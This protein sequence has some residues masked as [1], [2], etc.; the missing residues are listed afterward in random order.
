MMKSGKP[1]FI[2]ESVEK[3]VKFYTEKLGFDLVDAATNPE[4]PNKV[5]FAEI[6]KGK[7]HIIF[8]IPYVGELAELS[9][10]KGCTG[11]G[12][13]VYVEMKKGI[14]KFFERCEK[15]GVTV[16]HQ[17]K[18]Q[19]WGVVEFMI[20][21]PFGLRLTFAQPLE[22]GIPTDMVRTFCGLEVKESEL[23][24]GLGK[25]EPVVEKMIKWLKGFG[26]LRRVAKK[27]VRVWYKRYIAIT[28]K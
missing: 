19:S 28:K 22:E 3:V 4:A 14:E 17:P 7:C 20:K 6:R 21:D 24:S 8:R 15:K 9:M 10:V 23:A 18:R 12:S 16:V 26:I 25:D 2:V 27:F 11:R 5:A 13:G 1:L